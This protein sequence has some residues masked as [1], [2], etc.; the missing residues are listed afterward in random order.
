M[1]K[2]PRLIEVPEPEF[3]GDWEHMTQDQM[4]ALGFGTDFIAPEVPL[5]EQARAA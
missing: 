4:A 5:L 1:S 3:I 2:K